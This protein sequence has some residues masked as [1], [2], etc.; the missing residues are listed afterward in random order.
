ME[1][2]GF[3]AAI[4]CFY[5]SY[6]VPISGDLKSLILIISINFIA[7]LLAS[8]LVQKESFKMDKWL[9]G[10]VAELFVFSV[11][12]VSIYYIGKQKCKPDETMY[13]VS[14]IS[15][16]CYFFYG[17]N[18]FKNL[19]RLFPS[20]RA[21]AFLFYVLSFEFMKKMPYLENFINEEKK[22]KYGNNT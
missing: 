4:W 11:I 6:V 5:I 20:N 17:I 18:I 12:L 15:Y 9:K 19:K 8:L 10:W 1:N 22:D 7:G 2:K 3:V 13:C 21:I 14:F 16:S